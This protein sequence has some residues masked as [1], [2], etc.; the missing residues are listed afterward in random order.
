MRRST[1]TGSPRQSQ[2][3]LK[4]WPL[5]TRRLGAWFIE[6]SF[7]ASSVLLPYGIGLYAKSHSTEAVV[8]LNPG[9]VAVE[10]GIGKTLAIPIGKGNQVVKPLTNLFWS[11]AL[12]FPLILAGSQLYLLAKTGQTSPKR[13]WGV[14]VVT[15]AGE[16]PGF[17]RVLLR[18]SLG[19]WGLP[20]GIAYSI[21]RYS[22]AFPSLSILAGLTAGF[23]FAENFSARFH[24]QRRALHDRLAGTYVLDAGRAFY[25][26]PDHFRAS[27][28]L[29][30]AFPVQLE[31]SPNGTEA[32]EDAAIAAIVL[33][34][35]KRLQRRGLWLWMRQHPGNRG[36]GRHGFGIRDLC[37]NT[38]LYSKSGEPA[39]F[40]ATQQ[41]NFSGVSPSLKS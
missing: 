31:M 27:Q 12:V 22:G 14:R 3:R 32:E 37:W 7:L 13:W 11:A 41:P 38:S 23:W 30:R 34:P 20:F 33:A 24:P 1:R 17:G 18:E 6:V 28:E 40:C 9:L 35:E 39:R 15:A 26:Y 4:R 25:P 16:S 5:A 8:P 36:P 2:R 10:Q 29:R 21:W 19:R